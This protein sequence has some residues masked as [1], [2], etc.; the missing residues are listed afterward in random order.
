[1]PWE[2]E[3]AALPAQAPLDA[4]IRLFYQGIYVSEAELPADVLD[5]SAGWI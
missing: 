1:M 2:E 4:L 3:L 5:G